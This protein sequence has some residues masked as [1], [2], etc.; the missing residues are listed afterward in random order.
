[1][2]NDWLYELDEEG[3][4]P[5]LR[6]LTSGNSGATLL[7]LNVAEETGA[8]KPKES[9]HVAAAAGH[10]ERVRELLDEG[11]DPNAM[12]AN[13]LA[14]MHRAAMNGSL[15]LAKLLINRGADVNA[16]EQ[17]VTAMTPLSLARWMGY[18]DVATY[19]ANYGGMP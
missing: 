12:D 14:L 18:H 17:Q 6:G 7:I 8:E 2:S 5:L 11:A 10:V 19:I 3:Q 16:R 9:I 13:G 15:D 1:M 4:T